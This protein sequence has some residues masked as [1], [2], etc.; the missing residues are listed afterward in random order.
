MELWLGD[1]LD[2]VSAARTP[3]LASEM[4]T[5][6]SIYEREPAE[7]EYFS[8]EQSL[9][10]KE[11]IAEDASTDDIGV[12]A[13]CHLPLSEPEE[14]LG[15]DRNDTRKCHFGRLGV[16]PREIT[17]GKTRKSTIGWQGVV[18]RAAS[19]SEPVEA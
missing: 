12:I 1:R 8:W 6:W 13:E 9:A 16:K 19:V 14:I 5:A 7:S 4:A 3:K 11:G 2:F 15:D 17:N 18:P 10:A